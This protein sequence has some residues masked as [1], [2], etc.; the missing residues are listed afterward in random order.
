MDTTN[1]TV[2]AARAILLKRGFWAK[3]DMTYVLLK[4]SLGILLDPRGKIAHSLYGGGSE[5]KIWTYAKQLGPNS[6][7]EFTECGLMSAIDAL[8][9]KEV[10]L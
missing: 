3:D 6:P 1:F 8:Q 5:P 7:F 4:T 2:E 10:P 9:C